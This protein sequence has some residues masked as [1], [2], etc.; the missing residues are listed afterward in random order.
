MNA[1]TRTTARKLLISAGVL[2]AAAAVAG[3]GTFG[4]FTSTT[5]ASETVS[6]GTV[7]IELG[8]NGAV[9]ELS[10]AATGLVPGDT[11]QRPVTLSNTGDQG[12]SGV[13]LTTAAAAGKSSLLDTDA[14]NGLQLTIQSCAGVWSEVSAR[15]YTCAE[16]ASTVLV[17]RPVIGSDLAL[18]GLKSLAAGSSDNLLV[19]LAFP[20]SADNSFQTLSST[21]EFT[22]TGTQRAAAAR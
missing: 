20:G 6:S 1:R 13:V 9:N 14:T 16:G 19:T 4:T 5:S 2:G 7:K 3:L 21:I 15:T 18:T 17:S 11:V 8:A 10:V 22:F 12:L